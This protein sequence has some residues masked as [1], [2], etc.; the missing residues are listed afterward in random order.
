MNW[1]RSE[2]V[3]W[4]QRSPALRRIKKHAEADARREAKAAHEKEIERVRM[5]SE[6]DPDAFMRY[7]KRWYR[8]YQKEK[9][10][11]RRIERNKQRAEREAREVL[12]R[13]EEKRCASGC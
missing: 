4:L 2:I 3:E 6:M 13:P 1:N 10:A 8:A 7:V 12:H 9:R 5:L 11:A